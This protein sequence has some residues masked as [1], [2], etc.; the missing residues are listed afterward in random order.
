MNS[1]P[2][3]EEMRAKNVISLKNRKNL[4]LI[5]IFT[6]QLNDPIIGIDGDLKIICV[7]EAAQ[8]LYGYSEHDLLDKN[9]DILIYIKL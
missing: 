9:L 5:K 2:T 4:Q 7:N 6:R 1:E 3:V 8:E